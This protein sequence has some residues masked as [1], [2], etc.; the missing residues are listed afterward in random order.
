M[1]AISL[2][3]GD[4]AALTASV[5]MEDRQAD[6]SGPCSSVGKLGLITCQLYSRTGRT[7]VF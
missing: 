1:D 2:S 5:K 6:E 3:G 7:L 4:M